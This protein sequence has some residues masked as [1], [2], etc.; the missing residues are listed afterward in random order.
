MYYCEKRADR[1]TYVGNDE[2]LFNQQGKSGLVNSFSEKGLKDHVQYGFLTGRKAEGDRVLV[3][4]VYIPEQ[5]SHFV[6]SSF[7]ESPIESA[8]LY[9]KS[10]GED[11]LGVVK[12]NGIFVPTSDDTVRELRSDCLENIPEYNNIFISIN[13]DSIGGVVDVDR[14][15]DKTT[16]LR[17]SDYEKLNIPAYSATP[18]VVEEEKTPSSD[19]A[20]KVVFVVISKPGLN[21]LEGKLQKQG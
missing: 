21:S 3:N 5:N 18:K 20:E 10:R 16:M 1:R 17:Y 4:D 11:V 14:S 15:R 6:K 12:Y 8:K 13:R 9:A 19:V 7:N 2:V